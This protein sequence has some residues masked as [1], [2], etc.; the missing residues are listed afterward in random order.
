MD[1]YAA[2]KHTN[3]RAWLAAHHRFVVH[4]TPTHASG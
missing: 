1:N 3:V 2:H 4:F